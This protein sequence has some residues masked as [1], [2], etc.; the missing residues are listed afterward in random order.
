[1]IPLSAITEVARLVGRKFKAEQVI[2]FG[3]YARQ[4]ATDDSDVDLLVIT[5]G[6]APRV[7]LG[8]EMR[9]AVAHFHPMPLDLVLRSRASV[10]QW[11]SVPYTLIHEA[12]REGS[13]LYDRRTD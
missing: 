12:I 1:M 7:K 13:V 8:V 9:R 6:E 10:E 3:S 11:R 4:Q 5:E 2:L